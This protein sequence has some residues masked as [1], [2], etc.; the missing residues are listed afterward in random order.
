MPLEFA[1][2]KLILS[3]RSNQKNVPWTNCMCVVVRSSFGGTGWRSPA[4]QIIFHKRATKYRS[5]L[6]KMTYTDKGSYESSPPC[7]RLHEF[8]DSFMSSRVIPHIWL[9]CRSFSTKEPLNIGL[10][11]RKWPV[12][13]RDVRDSMNSTTVLCQVVSHHTYG[14]V[15]SH[16]WGNATHVN[17]RCHCF[18]NR[19]ILRKVL[20]RVM[21]LHAFEWIMSHIWIGHACHTWMRHHHLFMSYRHSFATKRNSRR[22]CAESYHTTHTNRSYELYKWAT[23]LLCN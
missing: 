8:H 17:E 2:P 21:S 3:T 13:I 19:Q 20:R 22:C 1:F 16:T 23:S 5:L 11:C 15:I 14:W 6:Q 10:F 12:K 4:L 9:S 7:T 18:E